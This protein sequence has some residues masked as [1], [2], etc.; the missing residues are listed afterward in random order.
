MLFLKQQQYAV[1]V[2][3][4]INISTYTCRYTV[5]SKTSL[6]VVACK[7]RYNQDCMIGA[8][9]VWVRN[10]L[11][12]VEPGGLRDRSP[13]LGPIAKHGNKEGNSQRKV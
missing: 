10:L 9:Q 11:K 8:S 6:F 13:T 3:R 4:N 12:G 5:P 1:V 7:H 2:T